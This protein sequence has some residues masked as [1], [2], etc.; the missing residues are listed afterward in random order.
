MP[1]MT[2]KSEVLSCIECGMPVEPWGPYR[3]GDICVCKRC[4]QDRFSMG[5]FN[6]KEFLDWCGTVT[7]V[8]VA[9]CV[10]I[11]AIAGAAWF[12]RMAIS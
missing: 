11:C 6:R 3:H 4:M 1:D 5:K 12:L 2:H 9:A 10:L 8:A 7:A